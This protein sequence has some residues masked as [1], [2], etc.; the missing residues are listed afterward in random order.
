MLLADH[1]CYICLENIFTGYK[2]SE[3]CMNDPLVVK[4]YFFVS[5]QLPHLQLNMI[6]YS[7]MYW[8]HFLVADNQHPRYTVNK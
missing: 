1:D 3:L 6:N 8:N 5:Q 4:I 7:S 2:M